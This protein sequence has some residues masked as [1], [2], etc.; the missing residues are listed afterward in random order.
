[1]RTIK[2]GACRRRT[3]A[4]EYLVADVSDR[5][6]NDNQN[7]YTTAS[8]DYGARFEYIKALHSGNWEFLPAA[9]SLGTAGIGALR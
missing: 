9:M 3:A 8:S 4:V 2:L 1:M 6:Q 5:G 7:Q